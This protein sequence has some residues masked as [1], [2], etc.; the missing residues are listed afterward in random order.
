[1]TQREI[2]FRSESWGSSGVDLTVT[3]KGLEVGGHYDGGYGGIAGFSISWAELERARE[4]VDSRAEIANPI[5][6]TPRES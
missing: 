4:L 1:V 5:I 2:S 6:Q 3:R